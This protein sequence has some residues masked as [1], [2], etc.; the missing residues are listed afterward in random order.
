MITATTPDF[1]S[2]I[3]TA[4]SDVVTAVTEFLLGVIRLALALIPVL[5]IVLL[6]WG[7]IA[8]C[9]TSFCQILE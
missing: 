8:F 7:N 1:W 2:E 4:F 6:L 3:R 5:L 9:A